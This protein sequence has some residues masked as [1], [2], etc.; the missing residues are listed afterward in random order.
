[1]TGNVYSTYELARD[2]AQEKLKELEQDIFICSCSYKSGKEFVLKIRDE[3]MNGAD[4]LHMVKL[5]FKHHFKSKSNAERE[6]E[7]FASKK[8]VPIYVGKK[9]DLVK[10][11]NNIAHYFLT[12]K[13]PCSM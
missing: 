8:G 3:M 2:K 9:T 6:A 11:Y 13:E 5:P 10:G 12:K 4:Y 1:M 7:I